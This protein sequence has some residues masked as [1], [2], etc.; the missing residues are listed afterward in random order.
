MESYQFDWGVI[1]RN[2]QAFLDALV[3]SLE[4]AGAALAIGLSLGLALAY[5]MRSRPRVVATTA[6]AF[7]AV[8]R[9]TPLLL[10]VFVVY[11]VLPE[12]GLRG[13]SAPATL[14]IALS[15]VASGYIAENLR[16]AF[17][18]IPEG[19]R[20]GAKAIGLNTLQ[21]EIYVIFPIAIRYALPAL[22]NSA[23]AVFKDT[24]LAAIIGV[25]ELTYLAREITTNTFQVF[26]AWASV[27]LIYLAVTAA[28]ALIM[29][30]LEARLARLS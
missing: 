6:T 22:T 21:R 3:L 28:M 16:A 23:V 9:N 14:V 10:F 11:L 20:A 29:R 5:L 15:V 27:A 12:Y 4:M 19:Y 24:S 7:V 26:E 13:V 17:A 1:G 8:T 2:R 18:T 25:K 30:G